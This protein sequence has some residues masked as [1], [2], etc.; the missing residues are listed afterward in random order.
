MRTQTC[1]GQLNLRTGRLVDMGRDAQRDGQIVRSK[2][3]VP[4]PGVAAP[5]AGYLACPQ[6]VPGAPGVVVGM[7]L[8]GVTAH[9]RDVCDRLAGLGYAALAPDLYHRLEPGAELAEDDQGRVRGFALLGGL[10]REGVVADIAATLDGLRA[11]GHAVRGM[12]GLSVGGHLAYLAATRLPLPA[13]VVAY[14]GWLPTTDIS[15]SRPEPT[16]ALTPGITGRVLVLVGEQDAVVPAEHRRAVA[17]AL[18]AAGV[19][20]TV[21]EFPGVG[22]G[23]LC[24]TRPTYD[25]DAAER[26]WQLIA[27]TLADAGERPCAAREMRHVGLG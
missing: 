23:F 13:V 18:A 25:A 2:V 27:G 4:V 17:E 5:M 10:T 8:F 6:G 22:H 1:L 12:V 21:V 15:V 3:T 26:A 14:G 11:R 24:D 7:E 19:P 20:H 9:V 16:L